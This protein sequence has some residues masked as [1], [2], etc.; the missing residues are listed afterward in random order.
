[1]ELDLDTMQWV[2]TAS[3]HSDLITTLSSLALSRAYMV[4]RRLGKLDKEDTA[5]ILA[6][7]CNP[8]GSM[9]VSIWAK[10]K[11]LAP[12][13]YADMLQKSSLTLT[14]EDLVADILSSRACRKDPA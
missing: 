11:E 12:L 10:W 14:T 7:L 4:P 5:V 13:M 9:E 3:T 2:S 6:T 8:N 1:M